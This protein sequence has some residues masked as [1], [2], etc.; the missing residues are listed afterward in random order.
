M[1]KRPLW[2]RS[3][4]GLLAKIGQRGRRHDGAGD[5][6]DRIKFTPAAGHAMPLFM[7]TWE[8]VMT[9]VNVFENRVLPAVPAKEKPLATRHS[10]PP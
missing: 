6:C 2:R 4:S 8:M 10:R 7:P 1:N 9:P 5:F 3:P